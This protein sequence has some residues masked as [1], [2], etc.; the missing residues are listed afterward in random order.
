[1]YMFREHT[2]LSDGTDPSAFA[3]RHLASVGFVVL[4]IQKQPNVF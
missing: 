1:M 4:Q 3:A 2:F